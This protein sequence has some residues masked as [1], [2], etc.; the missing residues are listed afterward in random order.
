MGSPLIGYWLGE[1]DQRYV[2]RVS[3]DRM[4]V[5][6]MERRIEELTVALADINR[7]A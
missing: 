3:E 6:E 7:P 2:Q 5:R 1:D 4:R